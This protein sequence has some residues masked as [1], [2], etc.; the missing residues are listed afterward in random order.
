LQSVLSSE[1]KVAEL[2]NRL[3]FAISEVENL[4]IQLSSYD[5]ILSHVQT[6][7]KKMEQKNVFIQIVNKNN[8]KLLSRLEKVVVSSN[9]WNLIPHV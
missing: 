9:H 6:T 8:E 7:I 1:H 3:D 4:E 5:E 2:I